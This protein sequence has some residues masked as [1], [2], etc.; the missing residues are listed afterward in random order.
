MQT[1]INATAC[2]LG[3]R[4]ENSCFEIQVAT[5]Y[6]F[7]MRETGN[8]NTCLIRAHPTTALTGLDE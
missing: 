1:E 2:A 6:S 8:F 5:P 7:Q 3:A 4:I